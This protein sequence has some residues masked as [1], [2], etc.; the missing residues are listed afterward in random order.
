MEATA[1]TVEHKIA[2]EVFFI[3]LLLIIGLLCRLQ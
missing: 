3:L 1:R 2:K